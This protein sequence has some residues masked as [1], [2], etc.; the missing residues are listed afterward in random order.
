M[1]LNNEIFKKTG[2]INPQVKKAS[3]FSGDGQNDSD[4]DGLPDWQESLWRTDK[5]NPDTDGDGTKDGEEIKQSRDPLKKGPDDK[6]SPSALTADSEIGNSM[7]E[8]F[9]VKI[10]SDYMSA[11]GSFDAMLSQSE[12]NNLTDSWMSDL[13][14]FQEKEKTGSVYKIGDIIISQDNSAVAIKKYGNEMGTIINKYLKPIPVS[15]HEISVFQSSL[16]NENEA[17]LQKLSGRIDAYSGIMKEGLL[18][19]VPESIALLHLSLINGFVGVA[20]GLKKM[21]IIFNDPIAGMAGFDQYRESSLTFS[22]AINDLN[23]FF[24]SKKIFFDKKEN[25]YVFKQ[26]TEGLL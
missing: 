12:K 23:N 8:N 18:L 21:K 22:T 9:G 13:S 20:D 15:E 2:E 4:N 16:E 1:I 5:N 7:T 6:I 26:I 24:E 3:I 11:K 17:E 25:G 19:E 14:S 10:F